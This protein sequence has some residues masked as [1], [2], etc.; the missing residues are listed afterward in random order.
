MRVS[1]P[2][3]YIY[4]SIV[5]RS[6]SLS[7]YYGLRNSPLPQKSSQ[8]R[9]MMH[10]WIPSQLCR[11]HNHARSEQN[12]FMTYIAPPVRII[13]DPLS[14]Q[15]D[16]PK[17]SIVAAKEGKSSLRYPLYDPFSIPT[18][19]PVGSATPHRQVSSRMTMAEAA[20]RMWLEKVYFNQYEHK[21]R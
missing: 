3:Q 7:R 10:P 20:T 1:R 5:H 11:R 21:G 16:I 13:S 8:I 2:G 12:C 18:T 9:W 17:G 15:I 19:Q 4:L 6:S 14:G